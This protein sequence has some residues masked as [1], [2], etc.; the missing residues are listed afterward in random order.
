MRRTF[1]NTG[2]GA[3]ADPAGFQMFNPTGYQGGPTY[4][5]VADASKGNQNIPLYAMVNGAPAVIGSLYNAA[6]QVQ[7][8]VQVPI[9]TPAP[10]AVPAALQ[11]ITVDVP[12]TQIS[13][14]LTDLLQPPYVYLVV[15]AAIFAAWHFSKRD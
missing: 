6:A 1:D 15:G 10:L 13:F 12:A 4:V 3:T 2:L 8:P 11:P 5:A 14:S 9:A 7:G